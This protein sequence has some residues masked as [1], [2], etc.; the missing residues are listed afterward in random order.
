M[1]LTPE[2]KAEIIELVRA[3][4]DGIN[5]TLKSLNIHKTTFYNWCYAYDEGG[6]E[7][8]YPRRRTKQQWNQIPDDVKAYVVTFAL[9]PENVE[10]SS[11]EIALRIT[12]KTKTYISES[13]VYRI[14]KKR[15]LIKQAEHYYV[16][17][18]DEFHT[19][20]IVPN[21]MWQ[22]DFTYFKI[23]GRGW[24]YLSTVIDDYS[25]YIIHWELCESMK[26]TDAGR[27]IATAMKKAGL[28]KGQA[29]KLLSD[30]GP[31]YVA[32][33]YGNYLEKEFGMQKIHGAPMH[34][35]TQGKIERY[36]KTIKSV[37]KLHNYYC[38]EE[39]ENAIA[40][41]VDYYNNQR[42]HESLKNCTPAQVYFGQ[43]E[44]VLKEREKIKKQTLKQRKLNYFA[45][46]EKIA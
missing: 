21:Q 23:I 26:W 18:A 22:T 2:E 14:L 41:F 32:R 19:K 25:R 1:R 28:R 9:K 8:L 20:T 34:P 15:G 35:Q 27:T 7:A 5:K 24:Y 30:N 46:L 43:D 4:P 11:R 12:D 44:Q 10:L 36:H 38:P 37:V 40:K 45:S 6:T 31:G 3:S 33:E 13:S 17:A 42:Y 16:F 29:P 39:L